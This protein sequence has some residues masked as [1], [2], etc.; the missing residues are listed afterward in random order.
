MNKLCYFYILETNPGE[1]EI[2]RDSVLY[3]LEGCSVLSPPEGEKCLGG[4]LLTQAW[5]GS[6]FTLMC[7]VLT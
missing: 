3:P 5:R 4:N 6:N 7:S 1:R 2:S